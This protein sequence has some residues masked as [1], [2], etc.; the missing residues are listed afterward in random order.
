MLG[1]VI[2]T[3]PTPT[4]DAVTPMD[5]EQIGI[6]QA[7]VQQQR[8][9]GYAH[10]IEHAVRRK[11]TFNK[12]L[13]AKFPRE[14]IFTPGQLVQVYHNDLTY[15]FKTE[16]KL[17]PCWS[18][19]RWVVS[20]NQ[21]L[22]HLETLEGIPMLSTFSSRHLRCFLPRSGTQL[23]QQQ[24]KLELQL[25]T[26]IESV[27]TEEGA[28]NSDD[29][30]DIPDIGDGIDGGDVESVVGDDIDGTEDGDL[31]SETEEEVEEE[32]PIVGNGFVEEVEV[33]LEGSRT[34]L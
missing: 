27:E 19:P 21:N 5:T 28:N 29:V 23:A 22:Y 17:L 2:N 33:E 32:D 25:Q 10:T 13:L 18:P 24:E 7:Y 3:N 6:H 14:V 16:C 30:E 1:L 15:M 26:V 8:L 4:T 20:R 11:G 31:E 9:D 34:P 12:R